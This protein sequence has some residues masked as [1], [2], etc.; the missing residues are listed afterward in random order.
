MFFLRYPTT[1]SRLANLRFT[2]CEIQIVTIADHIWNEAEH[3]IAYKTPHGQP[4]AVQQALLKTLRGQLNLVRGTVDQLMDATDQQRVEASAPID[5]PEDLRRALEVRSARRLVGDFEGLLDL[6]LGVLRDV[7]RAELHHLP[8]STGHLDAAKI[9]LERVGQSASSE[10]LSLIV[11]ALWQ[12][13]GMEF[14]EIVKG[15]PGRPGPL[16]RVV[17]AL[18]KA[19][20]DG[21]I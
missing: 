11:S 14:V 2:S 7:T 10:D 6:L 20:K 19:G 9:L 13:Y 8:L 21:K 15:W 12:L 4:T 1:S 16:S 3:D 17:R 18:D 5:S